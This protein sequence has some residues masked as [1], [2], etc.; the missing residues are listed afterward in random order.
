M[1]LIRNKQLSLSP[2]QTLQMITEQPLNSGLLSSKNLVARGCYR[3][4]FLS[5]QLQSLRNGKKQ[6][7][8]RV[9]IADGKSLK[10]LASSVLKRFANGC[11]GL[12]TSG[13]GTYPALPYVYAIHFYKETRA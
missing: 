5:H 8:D 11:E 13:C 1:N 4:R 6:I 3:I 9:S 10:C 7:V 2:S 12:E